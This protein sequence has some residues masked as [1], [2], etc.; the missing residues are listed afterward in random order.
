MNA[1]LTRAKSAAGKGESTARTTSQ[2][3]V[4]RAD[5]VARRDHHAVPDVD[6]PAA[7]REA[8][9]EHR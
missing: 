3:P 9:G 6:A 4:A 8:L 1:I 7:R 2:Q 5:G